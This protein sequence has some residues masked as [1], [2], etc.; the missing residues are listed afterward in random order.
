MTPPPAVAGAGATK[1]AGSP[2]AA[3]G[4]MRAAVLRAPGALEIRQVR[5][6]DPAPGEV[7]VRLEG[8]GVCASNLPPWE[9]REWFKYPMAPGQLGH[10][11]WGRVDAVGRSVREFR[12]GQRVAFLSNNAY[13]EYDVARED[14]VIAL[15]EALADQPFPAE[16]LGCAVNIFRRS[17]IEP[18]Q[19]VAIVGI[20]FLGALL[21]QLATK[22][23]A[24]VIA[25]SRRPFS[26]DF[27]RT[28]GAAH[29]IE[30]DDHYRI[31][32]EVRQLTGGQFCDVVIEAV[33]KQWPLDLSAELTRERGRL[34]VAGYHQDGP[35][36]VNMQLWNWRG[37]DVINAHERDP[38]VYLRGMREAADAVVAG[39]INP[40]PLYTHTFPLDRLGEALEMTRE[41]PDGFLKAL[42]RM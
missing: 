22:A 31:I 27:A 32:E 16:P 34:V 23:G 14:Q 15:P 8:C 20:G 40:A 11:G 30:M 18:G 41:R 37:L 5:I 38:R 1:A 12:V 7:R 35:R 6:P 24:R 39:R 29:V 4:T 10:E 25:I 2:Q 3:T 33:G 17:A 42:V 13:A 19:T 21:T 28:A 36:Q 26:L 9:G